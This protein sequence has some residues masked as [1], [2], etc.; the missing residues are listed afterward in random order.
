ME[1][2]KRII[3]KHGQGKGY[4]TISKQLDVPLTTPANIIMKFEVY[5]TVAKLSEHGCK[6]KMN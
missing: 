3:A 4:K 5:S 2:K 6:R 1:T